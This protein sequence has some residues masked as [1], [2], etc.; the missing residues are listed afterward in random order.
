MDKNKARI[1]M[2]LFGNFVGGISVGL[3]KTAQLGTD[4]FQCLVNGLQR[5]FSLRYGT[6]YVLVNMLLLI[7]IFML[8]KRYIGISTFINV[9]LLGY[10]VELST[11]I[12]NLIFVNPNLLTRIIILILGIV[13]MCYAAS[14]Y[15]TANLGVSTYDAISLIMA[16]HKIHKFKF[17]R[18]GC[19]LICIIIGFLLHAVVGIGTLVTALFMG[20]LIEYFSRKIARPMLDRFTE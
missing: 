9:F 16:D 12:L 10:V 8:N 20:P 7:I 18:M 2:A 17:C 13:I 6:L 19:D 11:Y 3:F 5:M 1:I 15:F 4:P 14:F